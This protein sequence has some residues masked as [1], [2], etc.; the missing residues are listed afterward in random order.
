[1]LQKIETKTKLACCECGTTIEAGCSCGAPYLPAGKRAEWAVTHHPE[2]SDRAIA[3]EIGVAPNTVKAAR[4]KSTAQN[5]T[6]REGLD[7]KTRRMPQATTN[8]VPIKRSVGLQELIDS[9]EFQKKMAEY[10]RESAETAKRQGIKHYHYDLKPISKDRLNLLCIIGS[11]SDYSKE[12]DFS[13]LETKDLERAR[14]VTETFLGRIDKVLK[15]RS[16]R[17]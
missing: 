3:K 7:G 1:M 5:C 2:K 11:I 15:Q 8:V 9:P 14:K 6:V 10:R 17:Q 12:I 16:K 13:S 4:P